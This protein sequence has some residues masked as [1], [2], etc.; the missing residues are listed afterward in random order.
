MQERPEGYLSYMLRLY[1]TEQPGREPTWQA[2]LQVPGD[3]SPQQ[4]DSL[5]AVVRYLEG[6]MDGVKAMM[7]DS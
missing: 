2:T 3:P 5:E 4:F 1:L 6:K 7:R